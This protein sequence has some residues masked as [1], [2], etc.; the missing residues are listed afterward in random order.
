MSEHAGHR[1]LV[2]FTSLAI[3]G[4]GL[5]AAGAYFELVHA[6]VDVPA[7]AAGAA[8]LAAG[9]AVSMSHL[10]RQRRAGLA[11]RGAGRSALSNEAIVAALALVSAALAAGLELRG[12]HARG[13]IAAAGALNAAFLVSVGLVYRVRGQRTWQGFAAVTPL[14]GGLAFGAI[15][16]Q[17]MHADGGVL[18]ASLVIVAVDALMFT[19]RWRDVESV[20]LTEAMFADPWMPRRTQLLAARFFLLDVIPFLVL[21]F[22]PTPV[23]AFA[24]A[25]GLVVDRF[26]F[27]AL[28]LQHTTEHEVDRVEALM[29][30][31]DRSGEPGSSDP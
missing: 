28:A 9:L 3:A 16:V 26:G 8:L 19:Q 7:L 13:V 23:A 27:Y 29:A 11:V 4:A 2:V 17:S 10:G 30:A 6:L 1:S 15:A 5:V 25:A 21:A 18:L 14:T 22:S 31:L 24:A 12:T 20:A